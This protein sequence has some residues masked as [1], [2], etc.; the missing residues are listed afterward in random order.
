MK[1]APVIRA[2]Q[3]GGFEQVLVHTGQHYDHTMSEAFFRDL[4][5]P[6]PDINLEVGSGSHATQTAGIMVAFEPV[7]EQA[8]PDW[9]L[10]YG[11]VNSTIACAL[12]AA[13]AAVRIAH[14]EAGLRSRD[15]TMPEELNRLLTDQLADLCFTPSRDGDDNLLAEGIPESRIHFVGNVMVDTLRH[16]LSRAR[17]TRAPEKFG[18]AGGP[19]T[20]VTL[21]RPSNVDSPETLSELLAALDELAADMPVIFPIHPRT[22]SRI[23]Q[24]GLDGQVGRVRLVEPLGYLE[25]IALVDRARL[26]LTDSGGLQEETTVLGIPCLTARPNTERPITVTQGT[27]QLVASTRAAV[28]EAAHRVLRLPLNGKQLRVPDLWDGQA[29]ERIIARLASGS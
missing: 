20:F 26:V 18:L 4:D 23:E 17:G 12:V 14:V 7:L 19:Y 22:R 10:V 25:S 24:F 13:K 11:D 2:G 3:A 9:I 15:R 29:A 5:L 1:V 28:I 6:Q 21:H 8:A 16:L 27:N